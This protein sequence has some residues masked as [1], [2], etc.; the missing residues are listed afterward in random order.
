MLKKI[1][2]VS[3][4]LVA[5]FI[6]VVAT[7]PSHFHVER[8]V[9]ISAPPEVVFAFIND[10]HH[11]SA[12]SPWE[13]L[14]PG[15]K[16]EYSGSAQGVGARYDWVGND[17]VGSGSMRIEDSQAASRL[18]IALEFKAPFEAQNEAS[19]RLTPEAGATTVTW[20]MDGE[21]NFMFKAVGLFMNMDEAIG[22]DFQEG[23]SNLK[24]LAEAAPSL[25]KAATP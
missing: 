23:L 3:L 17:D 24:R 10:F 25:P 4:V 12:W 8:S 5:L 14:D 19:F 18:R 16:R 1:A 13:K 9:S 11:W 21:N 7:R 2:I 22:K 15:M 6:A 20:G